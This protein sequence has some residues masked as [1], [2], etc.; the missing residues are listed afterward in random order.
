MAQASQQLA[1]A[2]GGGD[3]TWGCR[4]RAA[5]GISPGRAGVAS[6][7]CAG[8]GLFSTSTAAVSHTIAAPP[9]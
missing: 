4:G 3:P 6:A 2:A 5:S 7:G 8:S 9:G 1:A